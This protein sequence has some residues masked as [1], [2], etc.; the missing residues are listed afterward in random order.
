MSAKAMCAA[1]GEREAAGFREG[2]PY[3]LQCLGGRLFGE[4]ELVCKC[5]T[6]YISGPMT[7]HPDLNRPAFDAAERLLRGLGCT[8]VF[9]PAAQDRPDGM[10]RERHM[11]LDLHELTSGRYSLLLQLPGSYKSEGAKAEAEVAKACGIAI[12]RLS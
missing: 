12:A 3:C 6:V 9:N 5:G 4:D 1:C 11:L 2:R 8:G 7:G 10:P